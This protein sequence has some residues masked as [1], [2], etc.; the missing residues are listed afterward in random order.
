MLV[1]ISF[2]RVAVTSISSPSPGD[3]GEMARLS[4]LKFTSPALTAPMTG[5][6]NRSSKN[7]EVVMAEARPMYTRDHILH[8]NPAD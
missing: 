7:P 6:N 5:T 3:D 1:E 4:T 2:V 8:F